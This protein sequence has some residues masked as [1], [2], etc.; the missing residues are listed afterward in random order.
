MLFRLNNVSETNFHTPVILPDVLEIQKGEHL[1]IT[2]PSGCG[3]STLLN[4]IA[5]LKPL[6]S[7]EIEFENI[8]Y[9]SL[10][11]KQLDALRASRF[12]FI[13]QQLHLIGH[14]TVQQN[15]C[16]AQQQANMAFTSDLIASL[17]LEPVAKKKT[18]NLSFG[19]AQRVAIARATANKPAVIFADE[20]TSSLDDNNTEKV[21]NLLFSEANKTGA[22]I[23]A[24]THDAR[25]QDRFD[26]VLELAK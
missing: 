15:I 26:N 25:I 1:L 10:K 17:G 5:G 19:Q 12:G 2:G 24:A 18:R 21:M 14:L 9:S 22:S 6:K 11:A 4:L 23:I 3:K 20:P 13:F 7:G 8:K 16:L